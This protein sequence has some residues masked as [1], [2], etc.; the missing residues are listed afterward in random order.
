MRMPSRLFEGVT[1]TP[2]GWGPFVSAVVPNP[3]CTQASW[4]AF[5]ELKNLTF[6]ILDLSKCSNGLCLPAYPF[7]LQPH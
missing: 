4:K 1:P 5:W 3:A 7:R 2:A 6:P